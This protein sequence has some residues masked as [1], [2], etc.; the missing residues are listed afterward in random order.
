MTDRERLADEAAR[1]VA[2]MDADDWSD[3]DE[4]ALA[5]W[6]DAN[7]RGRG[8]LL[9][10]Q[11]AWAMLDRRTPA[12][13]AITAI[14]SPRIDSR[15]GGTRRP[16]VAGLIAASIALAVAMPVL[17]D[18]ATTYETA[19][20]DVRRVE[21]PDGSRATINTASRV[22]ID[23]DAAERDAHVDAG[24]A[25]FEVAKNPAR[26]FVVRAGDVSVVAVGT[27]FSV[28]RTATGAEVLVT[29]GKVRVRS[30]T[31]D[32]EILLSAGE[33]ASVAAHGPPRAV[34]V[35]AAS[36]ARALAWRSGRIDFEGTSVAAAIGEFNRYNRARLVLADPAIRDELLD[37]TFRID[38]AAGFARAVGQSL[39]VP[40]DTG[41]P[42]RI[43]IGK[44]P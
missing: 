14:P 37:G 11:A 26:P 8:A 25:W 22:R 39:D 19:I 15:R 23:Y 2:R 12:T 3:A 5:R 24:E 41:D 17:Y 38:D 10:A 43:V 20:G 4:A 1:W 36:I 13:A 7:P 29:E 32:A 30:I 28:R 16:F 42:Q 35:G 27:A 31:D 6:F 44:H 33:R 18:P 34:T 9:E 21:L 40:V